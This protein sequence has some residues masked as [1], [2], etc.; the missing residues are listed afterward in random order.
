[1]S[2]NSNLRGKREI[3]EKIRCSGCPGF[4]TR[5]HLCENC[6]KPY[7]SACAKFKFIRFKKECLNCCRKC[8]VS[9][10]PPTELTSTVLKQSS[11]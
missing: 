1:M 2:A 4:L 9:L 11:K 10:R 6:R 5:V 8:Q 7:H 3:R